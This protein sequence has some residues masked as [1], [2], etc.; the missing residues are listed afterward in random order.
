MH[1][2][3]WLIAVAHSDNQNELETLREHRTTVE[4]LG[5]ECRISYDSRDNVPDPIA[6]EGYLFLHALT[7]AE[8]VCSLQKQIFIERL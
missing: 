1:K 3:W 2:S 5:I 7:S 8:L 4:S 6:D